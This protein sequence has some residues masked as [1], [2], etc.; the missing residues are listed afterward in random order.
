MTK[1]DNYPI[2]SIYVLLRSLMSFFVITTKRDMSFFD[3]HRVTP[4]KDIQSVCGHLVPLGKWRTHE[5]Q[6]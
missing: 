6:R 4:K 3:K 2:G 5:A 1:K